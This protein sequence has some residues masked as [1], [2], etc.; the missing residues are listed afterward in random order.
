VVVVAVVVVV[1]VVVVDGVVVVVVAVV[2]VVVVFVVILIVY[3][4]DGRHR[5]FLHVRH[6]GS[7]E[8][9][10][11]VLDE[12]GQQLECR[13]AETLNAKRR[14]VVPVGG[15]RLAVAHARHVLVLRPRRG[16]GLHL[17]DGLRLCR[18]LPRLGPGPHRQCHAAVTV[19]PGRGP[20][21]AAAGKVI[22][23]GLGRRAG[24]PG[25]LARGPTSLATAPAPSLAHGP[26]LGWLARGR[27]MLMDT[28]SSDMAEA[29]TRQEVS[30]KARAAKGAARRNRLPPGTLTDAC[31]LSAAFMHPHPVASASTSLWPRA[32]HV[33]T[34][35]TVAT[36]SF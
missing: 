23:K 24:G 30:T 27:L 31:P 26:L 35:R 6:V 12:G 4:Q 18:A 3:L 25:R 14:Q 20:A 36:N 21:L 15:A 16:R 11:Q 19:A 22:A 34:L 7:A 8:L 33:A 9:V 13:V 29:A 32:L 17:S 2:V 1:V 28:P 5:A 10:L